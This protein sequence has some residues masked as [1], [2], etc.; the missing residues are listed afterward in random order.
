MMC[1]KDCEITETVY[2]G[3]EESYKGWEFW[4][5]CENCKIDTF[6]KTEHI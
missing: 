5:Y 6:H 1:G 4:C 3:D 2:T